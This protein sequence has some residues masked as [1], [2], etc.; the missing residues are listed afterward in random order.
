MCFT[1]IW[2][3]PKCDNNCLYLKVTVCC[4]SHLP[5]CLI[6]SLFLWFQ[7]FKYGMRYETPLSKVL[8]M[9]RFIVVFKPQNEKNTKLF[10]MTKNEQTWRSLKGKY[11]FDSSLNLIICWQLLL[12]LYRW[13]IF[14][15]HNASIFKQT[16]TNGK[17]KKK[18][19][20]SSFRWIQIQIIQIQVNA[21]TRTALL[22]PVVKTIQEYMWMH[23]CSKG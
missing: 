9:Y 6:E 19:P 3:I 20:S 11:G 22:K 8:N 4:R 15:L 10:Q 16:K 12:L 5:G 14:L 2:V 1:Q 18:S 13:C 23:K 7:L 21:A 17:K